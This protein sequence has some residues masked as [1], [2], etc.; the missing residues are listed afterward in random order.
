VS[1]IGFHLSAKFAALEAT[2]KN[3]ILLAMGSKE[4]YETKFIVNV[5][6]CNWLL[7]PKD[8]GAELWNVPPRILGLSLEALEIFPPGGDEP[9]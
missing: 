6:Q 9:Q 7:A 4:N 8:V 1:G 5:F 3:E 2:H